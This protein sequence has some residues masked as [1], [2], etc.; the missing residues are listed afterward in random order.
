MFVV[1]SQFKNCESEMAD[2]KG[3]KRGA[4]FDLDGVII[5]TEG[6]YSGFWSAID[7][8]FPTGVAHFSHIIKGMNLQ[9]ILG[10]YFPSPSVQTAVKQMLSDFQRNMR[11]EYF[12][13]AME[14]VCQLHSAGFA[15]AVVTSSDQK[16]MDALYL[17]HHE[18]TSM[19]DVIVT[20]DMVSHAKP[21]PQ[22]YQLAAEKVG[23]R[24][25]DCLVLED[26]LNGLKA[27]LASGAKVVGLTTTY[28]ADSVK[29]LC[30]CMVEGL[31]QLTVEK[32]MKI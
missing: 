23:C 30:H 4:L 15:T 19:F 18:F 11:Y 22:C 16:K 5:D 28:P 32:L 27:G 21:H 6:I 8:R 25:E 10:N 17:Q 2:E 31:H 7:E 24:I 13:G 29:P 14:L 9:E 1:I 3:M 26:S 12:P 20:G